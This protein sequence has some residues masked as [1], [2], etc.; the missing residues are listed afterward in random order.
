MPTHPE[1][2]LSTRKSESFKSDLSGDSSYTKDNLFYESKYVRKLKDRYKLP[3]VFDESKINKDGVLITE[4]KEIKDVVYGNYE[5]YMTEEFEDNIKR[6]YL[7]TEY[8]YN[9]AYSSNGSKLAKKLQVIEI[10][11][12]SDEIGS[13]MILL[14]AY[15]EKY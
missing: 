12:R 14:N 1:K 8:I 9:N 5:E 11:D 6:N 3:A 15:I 4:E 10:E 13:V 7:V 2:N